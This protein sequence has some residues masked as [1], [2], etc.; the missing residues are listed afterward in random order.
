MKSFQLSAGHLPRARTGAAVSTEP[1]QH[2][3]RDRAAHDN[4]C[5][6]L[7]LSAKCSRKEVCPRTRA[8]P[9]APQQLREHTQS[10]A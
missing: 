5:R 10:I 3:R 9:Q 6:G 8:A 2:P 1:A 7:R 4:V